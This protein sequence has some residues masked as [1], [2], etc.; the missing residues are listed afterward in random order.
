MPFWE[1]KIQIIK[2]S[3]TL[4]NKIIYMKAMKYIDGDPEYSIVCF[5]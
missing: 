5:L 1:V 4:G 2:L 3:H